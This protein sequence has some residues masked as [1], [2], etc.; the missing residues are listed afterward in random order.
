VSAATLAGPATSLA[1]FTANSV[2]R[3]WFTVMG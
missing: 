3:A 2:S 1:I